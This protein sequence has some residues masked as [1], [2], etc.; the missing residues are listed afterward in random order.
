MSWNKPIEDLLDKIRS[1]CI[2][3]SVI[4]SKSLVL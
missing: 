1:N 2:V 3:L 4:H